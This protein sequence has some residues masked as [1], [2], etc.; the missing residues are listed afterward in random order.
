[1][2][3]FFASCSKGLEYLLRDEL[4]ALGASKVHEARAG[5]HF[6]GDLQ[7]AYRACL[8]S[9]LASRILLPLAEFDAP[10]ADVLAGEVGQVDWSRHMHS[11]ASMAVD[12][13]CVQ[14][15]V[16][17]SR[18]AAQRVKDA[19][20]DQFRE[21]CGERPSVDLE[22]PDIRLNL[23][24]KRNRAILSLDLSGESLHRRGWRTSRVSA[25]LKENLAAAMLIRADWRTIHAA[26]G[27]LVDPM[28]GSATLLIEG[29]LMAADVAPGLGRERFGFTA[30]RGHD[31]DL[32]QGLQD[33]AAARAEEG[34]RKLKPV[35]FGSDH[36]SQALAAAKRNAQA[37]GVAGFMQLAKHDVA[38]AQ[39]PEGAHEHGLVVCNPPYGERLGADDDM[40][41]L[42]RRLGDRL[43]KRF[44]DWQVAIIIS[45][46]ELGHALGLRAHKHYQLFNGALECRLLLIDLAP[47]PEREPKPL[48]EAAKM[49]ANRLKK[50]QHHLQRRLQRE[51]IGCYRLYDRDLPEYAAA[52]DVYHARPA[53]QPEKALESW[54][55]VQE[56]QPPAEVPQQLARQRM[57]DMRRVLREQ[58]DVPAERVVMK[59]RR[60]GKGG[61]RYADFHK[62]DEWLEVVEDGLVLRVNLRDHIDTGLFLDHRRVRARVRELAQGR[63]FLNLFAY[64]GTASVHAAA[65]GAASTTSVDLSATYLQWAAQNLARNG[66][67]GP[68]HKL[69]QAD[70]FDFL[71]A[72]EFCYGLIFVDP[73]T[74]SNSARAED[75]DVQRDHV[76]LLTACHDILDDDGVLVFSN[77]ARRFRLDAAALE[78][79]YTIEDW[80]A[81]SI[82]FDFSRNPGIHGC[83]VLRPRSVANEIAPD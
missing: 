30:W 32:W 58:F 11:D 78:E 61:S 27:M 62:R 1:M 25:P 63:H 57:G 5:V 51:G 31:A 2:R 81:A 48:S 15:H 17:H 60:R 79:R 41:D 24:L 8:E 70:V 13:V 44:T 64:T 75:F 53:G 43:R 6:S 45:D 52:V 49:L 35:F 39:V 20:V 14:S 37:A 83:W 65:G 66:F 42:Y 71:Q 34:L 19:V 55:H 82:P 40:R 69:A 36:D 29:A 73:P 80:S 22:S 47:A 4:V 21:R 10:D 68:R 23:F 16:D 50:N 3:D 9:R 76:R 74:F 18:F 38:W 33:A 54:L 59:T 72:A 12:A 77:N 67:E 56:Y 7:T 28:C 46:K 26:G